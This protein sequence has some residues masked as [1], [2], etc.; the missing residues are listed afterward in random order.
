MYI[1][2]AKI[3]G[4]VK[5]FYD[6]NV[7]DIIIFIIAVLVIMLAFATGYIVGKQQIKE[8]IRIEQK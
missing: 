1:I 7:Y 3:H 4:F 6:R 5:H 2:L 8:P